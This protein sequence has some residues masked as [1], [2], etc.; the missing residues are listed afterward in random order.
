MYLSKNIC[1]WTVMFCKRTLSQSC[2]ARFFFLNNG[3]FR[4]SPV[5][6]TMPIFA[7]SKSSQETTIDSLGQFL[8]NLLE[9]PFSSSHLLFHLKNAITKDIAAISL[10]LKICNWTH[11][12][13]AVLYLGLMVLLTGKKCW[14]GFG[15]QTPLLVLVTNMMY[16]Q[17]LKVKSNIIQSARNHKVDEK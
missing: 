1:M 14:F 15:S 16:V 2:F 6:P 3:Y 10:F 5:S 11:Q 17:L 4:F 13:V 12:G 8:Q 7:F 9:I